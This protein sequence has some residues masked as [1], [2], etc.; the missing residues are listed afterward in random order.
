MEKPRRAIKCTNEKC[1]SI[2]GC[3]IGKV[4]SYC[5]SCDVRGNCRIICVED[6]SGGFCASCYTLKKLQQRRK[7]V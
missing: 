7:N 6:V 1:R 4:K 3:Q 5:K 2:Y